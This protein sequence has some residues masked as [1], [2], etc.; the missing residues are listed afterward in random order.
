MRRRIQYISL[1]VHTFFT[2]HKKHLIVSCLCGFLFTLLIFQAY[3]I[4][5]SF[6]GRKVHK[7]GVVGRYN[8]ANLPLFI[9]NQISIGMTQLDV[10]GEVKPS[11]ATG[12]QIDQKNLEYT[13]T[14]PQNSMWHSGK[15]FT[16]KDIRY[17]LKGATFTATNDT[18]LK[19][20]LTDAYAP[21]L[22]V[23]S[24]PLFLDNLD[25]LGSYKVSK[26]LYKEDAID[27]LTLTPFKDQTLPTMVYKFFRSTP[28][29]LFAFKAGE[30]DII[31]NLNDVSELKD[32]K[33]IKITDFIQYDKFIGIFFNLT[34]S[35]FKDKEI[36]QALAYALPK[37]PNSQKAYTP[38]SPL[39]WAYSSKIRLYNQ[40]LEA[41]QKIL[42]KSPLATSS[43]QITISTFASL[44]PLAE[45]IAQSWNS[46]G[47]SVKVKVEST[48]PDDYQ[49]ALLSQAI[50]PDPD[51]YQFWQ[52]TQD[53]FN[54]THYNNPK[55]DKL[56]EDGRK[57]QDKDERKKIYADFQR[58]IVDDAPV[59]FLE[60]PTIYTV[61]RK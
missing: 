28:D 54:I 12:W 39:S 47:V 31:M 23:L 58:Y 27:E 15:K 41:A 1:F 25:G 42:S 9:Q 45:Q 49:V 53:A 22:S 16:A 59:L 3:P 21:L 24:Q 40:D 30:L 52:S 55:I 2:R 43:N 48:L 38:I 35:L 18:T 33:N 14:F 50:P 51:Q 6:F 37:I 4:Y 61:E 20:T 8:I 26:L 17:A 10:N 11:L 57:T 29:V 44:L 32:W 7:I 34:N 46:V 5:L 36:R 19:V 60:F 13:F 56:L